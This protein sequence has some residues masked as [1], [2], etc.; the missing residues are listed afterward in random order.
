MPDL[1]HTFGGDLTLSPTGD[2][3]LS[4]GAQL[5][6]ERVLRRLL[7]APGTYVWQRDYGA[8]L[9]LFVGQVANKLRISA[10]ARAQ[11]YREDAVSRSPA[12]AVAVNAQPGSVVTLDIN[13]VDAGTQAAVGATFA[14]NTGDSLNRWR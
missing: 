13:Y 1:Q 8:G 10:I 6:Q 11:M 7:T 5:G 9:P 14:L 3:A 4:Q 2:L 12:P